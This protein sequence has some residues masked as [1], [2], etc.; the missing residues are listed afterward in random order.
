MT[1]PLISVKNLT[2]QFRTDEGLVTAVDDISF[3][4]APGEV[5]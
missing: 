2:I 1:Q 3:D 4:I 5:L